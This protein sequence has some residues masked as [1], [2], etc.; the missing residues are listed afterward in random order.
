MLASNL[1]FSSEKLLANFQL[2][3]LVEHMRTAYSGRCKSEAK[4]P[5]RELIFRREPFG[6]FGSMPAYSEK[7][8]L[9]I[10]KTAAMVA[11]NDRKSVH[12]LVVAFCAETGEPIAI[13]D[14][15]TVTNLKCMAASAL[16][17]AICAPPNASTLGVIGSG[18]QALVQIEAALS[19]R[20]ISK[21]KIYSRDPENRRRLARELQNQF[22]NLNVQAVDSSTE[23][24]AG[25]EIL[26]TA[27]T[28]LEPVVTEADLP[29]DL[30][31]LCVGAH[32]A[33]SRELPSTVLKLSRLIVEDIE[34]AVRE[35]GAVH[36]GATDLESLIQ[37]SGPSPLSGRTVFS[38]TGHAFLD[39]VTTSY[40]LNTLGAVRPARHG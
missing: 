30:F 36:Q 38:S 37:S 24:C 7:L 35:A 25:S 23:A 39:L 14:G 33:Q 19:V 5:P 1:F 11:R 26:V 17:T 16:V 40:L 2:P 27:T 12:A 4:V 10:N 18:N 6:A 32:T 22:S 8:G 34:T 3:R 21:I 31:V 13:L 29:A 9:F 15:A 28:S 20:P